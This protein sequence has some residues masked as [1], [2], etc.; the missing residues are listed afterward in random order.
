[1]TSSI[2]AQGNSARSVKNR[3]INKGAPTTKLRNVR[4]L[5]VRLISFPF[6]DHNLEPVHSWLSSCRCIAVSNG[7]NVNRQSQP[8]GTRN[9]R[10][11][12]HSSS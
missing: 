4:G 2:N 7:A 12:G 5:V 10:Q 1:M 11:L 3:V 6:F 9:H 8:P